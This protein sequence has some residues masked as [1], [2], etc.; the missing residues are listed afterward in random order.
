MP[1]FVTTQ[2]SLVVAAG[3]DNTSVA[4]DALAALYG[5]YWYPL[6]AYVRRRGRTADDARDV[7]QAFFLSLLERRDFSRLAR[8]RGR[9]RAF[10]L[11][12]MKHYLANDFGRRQALKRGGGA[13]PCALSL[14][15]AED[16]YAR[17]P[18]D[19]M[20][21]EMLYE[22][23]WA[24]T[25]IDQVLLTIRTEWC[26]QGRERVFEEFRDCLLGTRARGGYAETAARLAMSEGAVKTAVHR[27]RRRFQTELQKRVAETL[28]EPGDSDD[29]IRS[30][31]RALHT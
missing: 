15:G 20:T 31:I 7:V 4:R 13:T 25:V 17:E 26:A 3:N 28:S 19:P 29:E 10:L 27:L 11:A 5:I 21:P 1:G 22:R 30:L 8:E 12:S 18:A 2:W 6:Y 23:R 9:F 14:D 24:L 16:R